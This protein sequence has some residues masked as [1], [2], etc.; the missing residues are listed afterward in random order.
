MYHNVSPDLI[1]FAVWFDPD[2]LLQTKIY[3]YLVQKAFHRLFFFHCVSF[4]SVF[5]TKV[6]QDDIQF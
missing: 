5:K 3:V 1:L 4:I 6:G 2:L